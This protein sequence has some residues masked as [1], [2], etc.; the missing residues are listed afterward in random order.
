[1]SCVQTNVWCPNNVT[2]PQAFSPIA[3]GTRG[4]STNVLLPPGLVSSAGHPLTLLWHPQQ[5]QHILKAQDTL[6]KQDL[7]QEDA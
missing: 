6:G 5:L 1:M 4:Q 7:S 2:P 3:V